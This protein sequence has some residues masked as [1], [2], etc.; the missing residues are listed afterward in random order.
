MVAPI[1]SISIAVSAQLAETAEPALPVSVC[2]Y[3]RD[4]YDTN[5]PIRPA[6][7]A[8]EVKHAIAISNGTGDAVGWILIRRDGRAWYLDG[9]VRAPFPPVESARVALRALHVP[10]SAFAHAGVGQMIPLAQNLNL[11]PI[12]AASLKV[13][14]CY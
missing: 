6:L 9:P 12:I 7:H 10:P 14:S 1:F 11:S 13:D 3:A 2:R 8:T 4:W 5:I